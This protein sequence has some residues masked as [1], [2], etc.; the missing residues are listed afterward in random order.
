MFSQFSSSGGTAERAGNCSEE[1]VD[2][3]TSRTG[4]DEER[5][6]GRKA[7]AQ[8]LGAPTRLLH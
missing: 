3:F 7:P 6:P 2:Q 8:E 5:V 4:G 1:A